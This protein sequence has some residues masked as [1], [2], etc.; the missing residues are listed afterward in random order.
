ML[1]GC[2]GFELEHCRGLDMGG[3]FYTCDHLGHSFCNQ[4][5]DLF[6]KK[7]GFLWSFCEKDWIFIAFLER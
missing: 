4:S 7:M 2:R 6:G 5:F 1:E 3:I